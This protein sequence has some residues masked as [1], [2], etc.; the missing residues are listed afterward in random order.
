MEVVP[1]SLLEQITSPSPASCC[2]CIIALI[3]SASYEHEQCHI[4]MQ[5]L[6]LACNLFPFRVLAG[7]GCYFLDNPEHNSGTLNHVGQLLALQLLPLISFEE[8]MTLG[9]GLNNRIVNKLPLL[10]R[11][12]GVSRWDTFSLCPEEWQGTSYSLRIYPSCKLLS[13]AGWQCGAQSQDTFHPLPFSNLCPATFFT[14]SVSRYITQLH[15]RPR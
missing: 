12:G 10:K 11:K 7:S 6:P 1:L 8:M 5:L 9:G 3:I 2:N 15:P 4:K 14:P 13:S